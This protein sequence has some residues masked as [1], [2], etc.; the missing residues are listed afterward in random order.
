MTRIPAL[1]FNAKVERNSESSHY[2][3]GFFGREATEENRNRSVESYGQ[4]EGVPELKDGEIGL[5]VGGER[6]YRKRN[7]EREREGERER[8]RDCD[9]N[10]K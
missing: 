5:C 1:F 6:T 8:E 10:V 9:W 2:I 3:W 7:R 4:V